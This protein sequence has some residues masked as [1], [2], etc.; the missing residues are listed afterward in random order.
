MKKILFAFLTLVVFAILPLNVKADGTLQNNPQERIAFNGSGSCFLTDQGGVKCWGRNESGQVGDGTMGTDRYA[1]VDVV[2]LT[3]GVKAVSTGGQHACALMQTGGVKCWGLNSSGQLG[4]GT[5]ESP[6]N[7]QSTP[8]DVVG[9]SSGVKAISAGQLHTCAILETGGLKCWGYNYAGQLGNGYSQYSHGNDYIS[10]SSPVDVVGL[11][12]GVSRIASGFLHTCAILDSGDVKCWGLNE[13]GQIGDGTVEGDSTCALE[14]CGGIY[15]LLPT[16]VVGLASDAVA[17][18]TGAY[19]TCAV[20]DDTGLQ[21]WGKND[22]G[23]IGDGTVGN[24]RMSPVYVSGLSTGV[25][26]VSGG[27]GHTCALTTSGGMKCWGDDMFGQLGDSSSIENKLVPTDVFG[28]TS[29]VEAIGVGWWHTCALTNLGDVLC[30][31]RNHRG[32]LGDGTVNIDRPLPVG[33]YGFNTINPPPVE[34]GVGIVDETFTNPVTNAQGIVTLGVTDVNSGAP[35]ALLDINTSLISG[36][37]IWTNL[38]GSAD[39]TRSVLHYPGGIGELPG[40]DQ[41]EFTLFV[42]KGDGTSVLICPGATTLGQV[43]IGC[44]NGYYLDEYSPNVTIENISG[45]DY[46]KVTGLTGTGGMSVIVG[47]KDVLSRLQ[48]SEFS[49]HRIFFGTNYGI[50]TGET[51]EVQFDP[52]NLAF[53]LTGLTYSDMILTDSNA[54][55]RTLA[56]TAGAGVWGV[57]VDTVNDKIVFTAPT[58]STGIYEEAKGVILILNGTNKIKNPASVS[59]VQVVVTI[60]NTIGEEGIVSIP[61]V[62]S[63][64]VDISGYVTAFIHFDIDTNTDNTD[65]AYNVCKFHGGVGAGTADNYTVDLGEL[66]STIVNKSNTTSVN[67]SDGGTGIINSIY[68]DLTT[69]SPGGAIVTVNS[70]NS[71]LKGPGTTNLIESVTDGLDITANSG[72]YGFNLTT[73]STQKYGSI[74][75]NTSCDVVTEYCGPV[76]TPKTVFDTNN[77]PVDSARVRMDLAAAASYTNNPGVYTDTLTFVATGTF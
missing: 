60:Y 72:L 13:S 39:G 27:N 8:V 48:V 29:D 74:V 40:I 12:S 38:T 75:A 28:L 17:I 77:L 35:I 67:H 37:L 11:S 70:Q 45:I 19:H 32:Q 24:V 69:N 33:V 52:S 46:W 9:L 21:C 59:S 56:S 54:S 36:E 42:L 16:S 66:S 73:G 10:E 1:P 7:M 3:S 41:P 31:G 55:N 30:W 44:M 14:A 22:F 43:I 47:I 4:D 61:I 26:M 53:D 57:S 20:L 2:G 65:C 25:T 68:F 71:G 18:E 64:T 63:D 23:Q 6:E 76:S 51:F 15:R 50:N 34:S 58:N 49:D 62:D 5:L